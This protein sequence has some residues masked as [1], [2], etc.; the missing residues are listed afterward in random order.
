MIRLIH[1]VTDGREKIMNAL[2]MNI[3][4]AR[5]EALAAS[6]LASAA[7]QAV[8]MFVPPQNREELLSR[9][10]AFVDDTLNRSGPAKGGCARR[11]Q[12]TDAGD[13]PVSGHAE[14]GRNRAELQRSIDTKMI[15]AASARGVPRRRSWVQ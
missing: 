8:F 6:L 14:S 1:R 15:I 2:E 11:A 9:I 13:G 7:L 3:A 12:Y 10:T 5:G 4:V